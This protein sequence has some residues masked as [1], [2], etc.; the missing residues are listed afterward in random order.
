MSRQL[1][2]GVIAIALSLALTG[3]IV[4][5]PP[6]APV[7]RTPEAISPPPP[8]PTPTTPQVGVDIGEVRD[9]NDLY[10]PS[11]VSADT[12]LDLVIEPSIGTPTPGSLPHGDTSDAPVFDDPDGWFIAQTTGRIYSSFPGGEVMTCTGTVINWETGNIV[13]TAAHCLYSAVE[14][15]MAESV[16]FVPQE[17]GGGASAP[18]GSWEAERWAVPKIFID[19]ATEVDRRSQGAGW[20]WDYG[21]VRLHAS[22]SGAN[23]QDYTGG[24]GVSFTQ[25]FR[26]AQFV[27][28]PSNPPFDG[29]SQR[30]CSTSRLGFG[31]LYWPHLTMQCDISPG[32]SGSAWLTA[33]DP[34]TGAGYAGAVFSTLTESGETMVS[35]AMLGQSAYELLEWLIDQ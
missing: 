35:G 29:S 27:G 13:L 33:I 26:G 21:W 18:L 19:T 31:E 7:V 10:S 24:Q 30:V 20:A 5:P 8:S 15:V 14:Q 2:V 34:D 11:N 25:E 23:V 32:V 16:W 22:S 9:G 1:R 3:C 17:S 4:L 28:Y 12:P 6:P